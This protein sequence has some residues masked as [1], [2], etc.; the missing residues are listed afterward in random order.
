MS[1]TSPSYSAPM[2]DADDLQSVEEQ[3]DTEPAGTVPVDN[4]D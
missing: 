4:E 1:E 3:F 2:H